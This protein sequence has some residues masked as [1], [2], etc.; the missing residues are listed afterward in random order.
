MIERKQFKVN[1]NILG[2]RNL[3]SSGLLPIKRASVKVNVSSLFEAKFR[4]SCEDI[5]TQPKEGGPNPNFNYFIDF[6]LNLPIKD[7]YCPELPCQVFDSLFQ[8]NKP[9]TVGSFSIN[10][11][12]LI[13]EARLSR[14]KYIF[15]IENLQ[16]HLQEFLDGNHEPV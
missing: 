5:V 2:L 3:Q 12:R 1:I 15:D 4:H 11:S 9:D 14:D 10:M 16:T 13:K 8:W 7:K 6:L